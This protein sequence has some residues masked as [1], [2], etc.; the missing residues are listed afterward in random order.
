MV[1]ADKSVGVAGVGAAYPIATVATYVEEGTNHAVLSTGHQNRVLT[2][3]SGYEVPWIG[4]LGLVA[5]QKP[6]AGKDAL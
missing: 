5:Q 6:A 4:D 3:V 1:G 2:H